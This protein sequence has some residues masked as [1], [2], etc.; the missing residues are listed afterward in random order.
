MV[1]IISLTINSTRCSIPNVNTDTGEG[2]SAVTKVMMKDSWRRV[3]PGSKF[4]ACFG[5][6]AISVSKRGCISVGDPVSVLVTTSKHDRKV[7]VW[8]SE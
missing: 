4:D 3:D 8:G 2:G 6:N 5:M 1:P 7:G